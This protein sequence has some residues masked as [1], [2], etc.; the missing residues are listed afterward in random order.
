MKNL[1]FYGNCQTGSL[2]PFLKNYLNKYNVKNILC[3]HDLIEKNYFL[4]EIQ[5]ADVIITQPINSNYRGVDYLNTEFI[6]NNCKKNTKIIIFPSLHFDFYY[7][8]LIYKSLNNNILLRDPSDYHYGK[9]IECYKNSLDKQY[10]IDNY[11]NNLNYKSIEELENIANDSLKELER[12]ENLMEEYSNIYPITIIKTVDFIRENY[13]KKLLFYS[14]NH[15]TKYLMQ[16]ICTKI[17]EILEEN[18][19][20]IDLDIDPLYLNERGI[21]YKCIQNIVQFDINDYTPQ[22]SKYNINNIND[23]VDTYYNTYNKFNIVFT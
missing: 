15:P 16:F 11:I 13:K 9:L 22:L 21:I 23:V 1:L 14:M 4:E 17:L 3:W 2:I 10:F 19:N 7:F 12:R 8:D 5:K 18:L 6:L 20:F